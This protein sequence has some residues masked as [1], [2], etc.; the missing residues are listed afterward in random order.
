MLSSRVALGRAME[1]PSQMESQV[2]GFYNAGTL[3]LNNCVVTGNS[4]GGGNFL[5]GNAGGTSGAGAGASNNSGI[6]SLYHMRC[7][8][9][10]RGRGA[11]GGWGGTEG[12]LKRWRV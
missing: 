11:D 2:G 1:S 10:F 7:R 5:M 8:R 12:G 3:V 9:K 4:S 6:L